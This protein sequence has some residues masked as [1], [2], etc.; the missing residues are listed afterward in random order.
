MQTPSSRCCVRFQ[1]KAARDRM[2]NILSESGRHFD[3]P[4]LPDPSL[5]LDLR[6]DEIRNFADCPGVEYVL[7]VATETKYFNE[8][9]SNI[10]EEMRNDPHFQ[11]FK[12]EC[13]PHLFT[14]EHG[15]GRWVHWPTVAVGFFLGRGVPVQKAIEYT[16]GLFPN[17]RPSNYHRAG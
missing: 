11:A 4:V 1:D 10:T 3:L 12:T 17:A 8:Y 9:A 6:P 16:Q 5:Y 15:F 2:A 7:D 14:I 13:F